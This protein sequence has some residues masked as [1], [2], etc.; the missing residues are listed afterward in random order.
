MGK[1]RYG[2]K[3]PR[4]QQANA[5][6]N[7]MKRGIIIPG[8][9]KPKTYRPGCLALLQIRKMQRSTNLLIK[10]LPFQRLVRELTANL[11]PEL[12]IRF[13]SAALEALQVVFYFYLIKIFNIILF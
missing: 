9:Q 5:A 12:G 13:Q 10:K 6:Q 1:P 8:Q 3:S 7:K 4:M 11:F 2:G